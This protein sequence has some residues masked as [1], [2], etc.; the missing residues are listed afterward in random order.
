MHPDRPRATRSSYAASMKV[1]ASGAAVYASTPA[2]TEPAESDTVL[3]AL[4]HELGRADALVDAARHGNPEA[5]EALL[6]LLAPRLL[7][8]VR[9]LMG[10]A[11][12]DVEDLV[13]EALVDLV[14]ALASFRGESTLLHF[15]IRIATRK[16]T[17]KRRRAH[18]LRAWLEQCQ[19]AEEPLAVSPASPR[20]ELV[21]E[22]RRALLRELLS[23]L[24]EAQAEALVMRIALGYSIEDIAE[25]TRAPLN[26]VRSRLRLGKEALRTRVENDPRWAE[27]G[28]EES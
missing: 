7:R 9:A 6:T 8:A 17:K 18:A 23:A 1:E 25:I 14:S 28:V 11:H 16:V 12:P 26:T 15:A 24:P 13:Q 4:A 27:L 20:Q 5:V 10:P 21:A 19:R 2:D 22:R 3:P